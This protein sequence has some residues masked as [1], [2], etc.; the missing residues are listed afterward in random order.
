MGRLTQEM[1]LLTGTLDDIGEIAWDHTIL[2]FPPEHK[3]QVGHLQ[4]LF[5]LGVEWP[6]LEPLIRR[7]IRLPHH[8]AVDAA[9]W[10]IHKLHKGFAILTVHPVRLSPRELWALAK[11][12]FRIKS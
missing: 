9:F 6:W 10:W 7:L 8:R 1:G 4:R 12:F 5:A 3:R 11:H 2:A